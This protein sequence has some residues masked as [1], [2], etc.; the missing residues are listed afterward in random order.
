MSD[1]PEQMPMSELRTAQA[2]RL[3]DLTLIVLD[4]RSTIDM[5]RR[6]VDELEEEDQDALL[7]EALWTASLVKYSRCFATGRR[8][9]LDETIFDQFEGDPIGTHRYFIDMRNKD[10]AHAVNPFEEVRVGVVLSAEGPQTAKVEGVGVL[11]RKLISAEVDMVRNL[12]T[13]ASTLHK[14]VAELGKQEQDDLLKWAQ[15][16]PVS[17][18]PPGKLGLFTPG[19]EQV[20]RPRGC[21][22]V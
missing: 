13:L 21:C 11:A 16:R 6:L 19:P 22:A 18:F 10:V 2:E 4:L 17:E 5:C 20:G 3:G 12:M 7:I 1:N 9:G 14:K 15:G 8:L